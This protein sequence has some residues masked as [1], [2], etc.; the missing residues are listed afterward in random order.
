VPGPPLD[1]T[2]SER[3]LGDV[4][5]SSLDVDSDLQD[6]TGPAIHINKTPQKVIKLRGPKPPSHKHG[7]LNRLRKR[8]RQK[9]S[10]STKDDS[11]DDE[12]YTTYDDSD[13]MDTTLHQSIWEPVTS[14]DLVSLQHFR[15]AHLI[16]FAGRGHRRPNRSQYSHSA[17]VQV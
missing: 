8:K 4:G 9:M 16:L 12:R 7:P 13:G 15:W 11:D 10:K 17:Q 1:D 3:Q 14:N 2:P 6:V 5:G